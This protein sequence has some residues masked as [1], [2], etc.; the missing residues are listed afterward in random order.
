M[1]FVFVSVLCGS[2]RGGSAGGS[3][4]AGIVGWRT[5]YRHYGGGRAVLEPLVEGP[6]CCHRLCRGRAVVTADR[7]FGDTYL[8]YL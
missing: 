8:P 5:Q 1:F 4:S 7:L 3:Y 6:R 2:V